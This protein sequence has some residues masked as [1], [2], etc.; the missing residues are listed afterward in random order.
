LSVEGILVL[1]GG[2]CG[3]SLLFPRSD[4]A[5]DIGTHAGEDS[6]QVSLMEAVEHPLHAR[7]RM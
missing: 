5:L 6:V 2:A 7:M 3:F 1:P 4:T